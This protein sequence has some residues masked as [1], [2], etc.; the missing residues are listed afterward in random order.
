[1]KIFKTFILVS[2][3]VFFSLPLKGEEIIIECVWEGQTSIHKWEKSSSGK[4]QIFYKRKGKWLK[5][6]VSGKDEDWTYTRTIKY[7]NKR[8][9]C[10]TIGSD[11]LN[12]VNFEKIT[13]S[14]IDFEILKREIQTKLKTTFPDGE[15]TNKSFSR[16]YKCKKL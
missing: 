4:P 12:D 8:G 9:E 11:D 15:E 2:L 10:F 13:E 6:C 16:N 1:M 14:F 5:W 7:L 3:F